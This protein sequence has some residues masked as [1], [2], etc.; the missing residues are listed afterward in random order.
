[1]P[2]LNNNQ[3][4]GRATYPSH[5]QLQLPFEG[6]EN[7]GGGSEQMR[8]FDTH[9]AG[10]ANVYAMNPSAD[11]GDWRDVDRDVALEPEEEEVVFG[12]HDED[13]VPPGM[14]GQFFEF[15]SPPESEERHYLANQG[16]HQRSISESKQSGTY[17]GHDEYPSKVRPDLG[18]GD[19]EEEIGDY[20]ERRW[21]TDEGTEVGKIRFHEDDWGPNVDY[22]E[23]NPMYRGRGF[24]RD[25][26]TK[27]A[28][29]LEPGEGIMHA[30]SF[31]M[32]GSGAFHAKGVPTEHDIESGYEDFSEQRREEMFDPDTVR[33]RAAEIYPDEDPDF[34]DSDDADPYLHDARSEL[35][36][37]FQDREPELRMEFR[38]NLEEMQSQVLANLP[39]SRKGAFVEGW[40][41]KFPTSGKAEELPGMPQKYTGAFEG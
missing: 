25:A 13:Y 4:Q 19:L 9:R 31:T 28:G 29:G 35:L 18:F 14:D 21:V 5:Q 22:A 41:P 6:S 24:S 40:K 27:V 20:D 10:P 15:E 16:A 17:L 7:V 2:Q 8:L 33:E 37:E 12:A 36:G 1:M 3:F 39:S 30:G 23:I 32:A 38:D 26:L 34:W 11:V